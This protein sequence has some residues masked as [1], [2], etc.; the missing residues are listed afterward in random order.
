V[1]E[2]PEPPQAALALQPPRQLVTQRDDLERGR[3]H[4]LARVQ[5]ER[6]TRRHLHLG[7]QLVLPLGRVDVRV[8]VVVEHS[9]EPVQ[10]HVDAGRLHERRLER[11]Q[12][13]VARLDLGN[14]VAVGEQHRNTIPTCPAAFS[15]AVT[16]RPGA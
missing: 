16:A 14:E 11:L 12:G 4:E 2:Q 13:E 5:H 8:Q 6:L 15:Q 1:R 3:Q 7:G 10:P 9:E